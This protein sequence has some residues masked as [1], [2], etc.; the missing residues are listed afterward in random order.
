MARDYYLLSKRIGGATYN[1][2]GRMLSLGQITEADLRYYYSRARKTAL[3]RVQ[4]AAGTDVAFERNAPTFRRIPDIVTTSDLVHEIADVNR[5]LKAPTTVK[6]RR[7]RRA[8]TI[9][10]L[11]EKGIDFVTNEN[12]G[13]WSAFMDWAKSAGVFV[14]G[15]DSESDEVEETFAAAEKLGRA[16][17]AAYKEL[18]EAITGRDL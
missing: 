11:N 7:A 16:D 9:R 14:G 15:Y 13:R 6:A 8:D 3:K 17:V 2:I 1:Q 18:F 5:F 10:K 4:R 12:F